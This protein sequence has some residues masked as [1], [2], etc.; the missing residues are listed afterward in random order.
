MVL[1]EAGEDDILYCSECSYCVNAE[2]SDQKEGDTCTRCSKGTLARAKASEVGNIFD[3]GQKYTKDFDLTYQ[4]ADGQNKHP[5]MGCFGIGIT[6]LMGVAVEALADDKGIVWPESLAPF[7]VHLVE[8]SG[9]NEDVKKEAEEVYKTL[10]DAGVEVLYDDTD[11][12]AGEKF[13]DAD[14]VGIP[15]RVIVSQKTLAA[16]AF[17]CIERKGGKTSHRTLSELVSDLATH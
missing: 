13:A 17:E 12:R 7:A 4:D 11:R 10:T 6:R 5:I 15:L 14:L 1:T 8:L 2:I 3:L 9:G 16:G